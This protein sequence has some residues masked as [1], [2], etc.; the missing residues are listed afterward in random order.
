[1]GHLG[2]DDEIPLELQVVLE[3]FERWLLDF[4]DPFNR[5]SNKKV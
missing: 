4:V 5:P 3:P 1:M 2:Q